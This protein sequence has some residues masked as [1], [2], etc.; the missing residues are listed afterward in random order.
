MCKA[1][2]KRS[3]MLLPLETGLEVYGS[4]R[5]LGFGRRRCSG[6]LVC[7]DCVMEYVAT[8][9]A[10]SRKI[11]GAWIETSTKSAMIVCLVNDTYVTLTYCM[12]DSSNIQPL[13][14]KTTTLIVRWT[15][16]AK[17]RTCCWT[18]PTSTCASLTPWM[19]LP[20]SMRVFPLVPL[21]VFTSM[22]RIVTWIA[23]CPKIVP[24]KKPNA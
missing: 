11:Y 10:V 20:M 19:V 1:R 7:F 8:G 22:M 14:N 6:K 9:S 4:I 16:S 3:W 18:K 5:S 2:I 17:T 13:L 24:N 23:T 21:S 15:W 12:I